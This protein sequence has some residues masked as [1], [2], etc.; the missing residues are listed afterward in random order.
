MSHIARNLQA[1]GKIVDRTGWD[2]AKRQFFLSPHHPFHHFIH[3]A[4]AAAAD[5]QIIGIRKFFHHRCSIFG[6]T[7]GMNGD[8]ITCLR[9]YIDNIKQLISDLSSAGHGIIHEK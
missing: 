7:G 8:L 3:G 9:K 6:R 5:Y 2:I 4:V 1:P